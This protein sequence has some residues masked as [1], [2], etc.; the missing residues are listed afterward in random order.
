M[1]RIDVEIEDYL[2]EVDTKYLVRELEKRRDIKEF[3]DT[4]TLVNIELPEFRN[5]QELLKYIKKL[6][7]LRLWHDK[8]R[9]ISE[10]EDLFL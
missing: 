4:N 7:G 1:A 2:D 6:L 3:I 9:V 8:Q 10:I 5:R